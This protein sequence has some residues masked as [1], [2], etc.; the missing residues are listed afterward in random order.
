MAAHQTYEESKKLVFYGLKLLAIITIAE[1]LFALGAKGH[2]PG[3][4]SFYHHSI[5]RVI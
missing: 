5:G 1:V 4:P 3:I 2:L